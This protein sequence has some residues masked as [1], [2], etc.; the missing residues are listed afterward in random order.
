M[1]KL[2]TYR[3]LTGFAWLMLLAVVVFAFSAK[4]ANPC[5]SVI[6]LI[7]DQEEGRFVNYEE[8]NQW[9]ENW[10]GEFGKPEG[11]PEQLSLLE[12]RISQ[13]PAVASVQAWQGVNGQLYVEV[14]QRKP[15]AR[16]VNLRGEHAY[17]DES[18]TT[19]PADLGDPA[20]VM[21]VT[22]NLAFTASGDCAD[23]NSVLNEVFQ[24]VQ[25]IIRSDF[26]LPFT[27]QLH[28][29]SAGDFLLAPKLG[30]H[31][32]LLG[33]SQQQNGILTKL[34]HFYRQVLGPDGWNEYQ[35]IDARFKHQVVC[36]KTEYLPIK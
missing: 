14:W 34:E 1:K 20:R 36:S 4:D 3:L 29:N 19:F 9:V 33:K 6:V 13:H 8:V 27:E 24:W 2:N 32:V 21:L 18:G 31:L 15:V 26:W 23:S 28:R 7:Q 5:A 30:R 35:L 12:H 11:L 16:L 17:L 22:G 10:C 25:P